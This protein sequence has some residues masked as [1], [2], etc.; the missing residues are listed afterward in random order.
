MSYKRVCDCCGKDVTRTLFHYELKGHLAMDNEDL[1]RE[2]YYRIRDEI[3][4]SIN[5]QKEEIEE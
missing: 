1:C 5:Q 4:N 2:C 3:R